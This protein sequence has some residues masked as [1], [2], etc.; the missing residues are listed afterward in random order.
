LNCSD[1]ESLAKLRYLLQ[2]EGIGPHKLLQLVSKYKNLDGIIHAPYHSLLNN[3]GISNSL[4]TRIVK[5]VINLEETKEEVKV[6]F[7]KLNKLGGKYVTYWSKEYPE[8]LRNIYSPPIILY[9]YGDF[10]QND[11]N[12]VAIVGTRI[13]SNYG[14]RIAEKF[15]RELSQRNITIVSG[16]ARGIDSIC[17]DTAV[18]NKGRT[19]A[20]IGSGLDIIYPPENKKLFNSVIENGAVISEYPL[21]TQPDAQNF[22]KRNR[23]I[24]GIS[25]GTLVIETKKNGGAMQTAAFALNENREVFAVPG[26]IDSFQSEGTNLLIKKSEAKAVSKVEDILDE[27]NLVNSKKSELNKTSENFDLNLFEQR[28]VEKLNSEPK[29]I[30]LLAREVSMNVSDCSV[31]LLTLEFRGI[32]K[33]L[34]GKMF[35]L[36]NY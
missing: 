18:R 29:Q 21:G 26:N 16:L 4:A 15:T 1:F 32:V 28:I 14:R 3:Q 12:S 2:I 8:I 25:L 22:P 31:H 10:I 9:Y 27:L 30:D 34:P 5:S 36:E 23:I 35:V 13:P 7:D 33:Q 17:H 11:N 20:I 19:V 6:E 24:A